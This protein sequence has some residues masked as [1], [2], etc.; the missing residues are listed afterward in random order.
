MSELD[1]LPL[2]RRLVQELETGNAE[3][4]EQLLGQLSAQHQSSVF[5]QVAGLTRELHDALA[6][7]AGREAAAETL[8]Q[9]E[10]LAPLLE[11]LRAQGRAIAAE[12]GETVAAGRRAFAAEVE[13]AAARIQAGLLAIVRA[14]ER[15][16]R[17]GPLERRIAALVEALPAEA[18]HG[19]ESG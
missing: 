3:L 17:G 10:A 7:A 14:Q 16:G 13:Q 6:Q 9:I 18:V 8:A 19:V 5:E 12:R 11:R 2:A 1:R 4:A 15:P